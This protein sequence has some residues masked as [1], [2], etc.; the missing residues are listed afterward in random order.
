MSEATTRDPAAI[1]R[2]IRRT[3]DEMS[4]TVDKIGSQLT[5]RNILNA[6]LDKTEGGEIDTRALLDTARRNPMALALIAGGTI[7]LMSENDAKFAKMPSK[8]KMPGDPLAKLKGSHSEP[9]HGHYLAHMDKVEWRDGEDPVSY[10][11][12]RDAAR[13]SYFMVERGHDEDDAGFRQRLDDAT[14]KFRDSLSAKRRAFRETRH[15]MTAAISDG[16]SRAFRTTQETLIGNPLLGG[17]AAAAVGAILGTVIP[18]TETEEQKLSSLG[19]QAHDLA[20]EQTG[21]LTDTL[22]EKKDQ[23]VSKIEQAAQ[24]A[25]PSGSG[26]SGSGQGSSGQS[27]LSGSNGGNDDG[28]SVGQSGPAMRFA[29][30]DSADQPTLQDDGSRAGE[31]AGGSSMGNPPA[32]TLV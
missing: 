29:T 5:G 23:A 26:G 20:S 4:E 16:S 1:E 18:L 2:D 11:R 31:G 27:S 30:A 9:E 3:Q 6:L 21:K 12:R 17:L 15:D 8:P 13:A 22:R 32:R 10:Q 24:S 14:H 25:G 19:G 7:W 28:G